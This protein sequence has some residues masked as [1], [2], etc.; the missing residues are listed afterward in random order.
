MWKRHYTIILALTIC[1]CQNYSITQ[2]LENMYGQGVDFSGLAQSVNGYYTGEDIIT[3]DTLPTVVVYI[4]SASCHSC[5]MS[6]LSEFHDVLEFQKSS[7]EHSYNIVFIISPSKHGEKSAL[8]ATRFY[9][10]EE[11]FYI[12]RTNSFIDNN[13]F[14]SRDD[15]RFHTFLLDK[16]GNICLVGDPRRGEQMKQLYQNYLLSSH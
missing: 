11:P 10:G 2:K 1:G 12:D 3:L 9:H 15:H 5:I 8:L 16:Y 13:S 7:F 14:I 4:D 6:H